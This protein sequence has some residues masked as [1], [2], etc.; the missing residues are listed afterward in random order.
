MW[1]LR[2]LKKIQLLFNISFIFV[3]RPFLAFAAR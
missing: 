3:H 2:Y 1:T